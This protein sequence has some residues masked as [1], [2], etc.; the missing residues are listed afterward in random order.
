LILKKKKRMKHIYKIFVIIGALAVSACF[1]DPGS[2]TIFDGATV[3][4]INEAT[5]AAGASVGKAYERRNDGSVKRDSI[6]VNLVGE[7]VGT[8]TTVTFEINA[9]GT[10]AVAGVHYN[11]L[12]SGNSITI[13]ANSS[14]GYIY[15]EVL[16][17]NIEAG[18]NWNLKFALT[19]GDVKAS[20]NYGAFTRVIRIACPLVRDNFVGAFSAQEPGYSGS[21][22]DVNFIAD[23]D[24][25]N[26]VIVDNFWDFGGVVKY[27]FNANGTVTIPTQNV[28]MGGTTYVVKA[29]T[30]SSS[31]DACELT[32]KVPYKVETTGGALQDDNVHTFTKK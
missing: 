3:V 6:R 28:V 9:A 4:E 20:A 19:G 8:P 23:P 5:T 15:F 13:P 11:M 18:E 2:D 25:P 16:P 10:T 14:Y 26:G 32:F 27:V 24:E 30:G 31:Y 29:G 7:Q 21:P 1:D 17:D 12:T 22:Y